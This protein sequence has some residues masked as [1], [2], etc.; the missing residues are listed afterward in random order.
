MNNKIKKL[1]PQILTILFVILIFGFFTINAQVN[2]DNRGIDFGFGF[3]KQEASFDMQFTLLDYDGQDSY[4]WAYVVALLNTLLVSFLG[5]IFCTILGVIIGVARLS[6]NFLIRNSA[7]WYVEFFRNIPLLL[8][9]FFWYYAALRALPLPETAEPWFG[10]TYMTIK[11]YYIPSMIWENLNVFL[12]CLIAAIVSIIFIRIYARKL[13]EREGK[14]L[15]VFY[16]SIGLLIILPLLS[17][18]IGGVKLDFE[19]PV[20]KQLAQTSFIFEGGIALPPE[21]I[22]LVVALSLYTSTFVA[23]CVRAGIQGISKGQKEAAASVGLNPN[24]ILKLVI[25]P[26]ALRIIIP[27]T[28]NQYLNLTKNSSLAAAIAYPDLVLVFAGTAL[29]QTGKAIEIVGITML[30]YLTISL[31]IAA[32]MNW[33]NKRIEI[34][35]K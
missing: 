6:Q 33:Y 28:T 31:S 3:L 13:Q 24:Q 9:I 34:K 29:M 21:L 4:A 10:V 7:A 26:Q 27:P 22:A 35:E 20:L 5:I 32:L 19:L 25:M 23:E 30:T 12:S 16:I 18:L 11:G 15:P 17:F 2:M 14:Q 8:Q 1:I